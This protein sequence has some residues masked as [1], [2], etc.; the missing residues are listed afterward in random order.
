MSEPNRMRFHPIAVEICE[1]N[2]MAAL[3]DILE[4][5]ESGYDSSA[6]DYERLDHI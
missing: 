4:D 1:G 5:H 2:L 6:W 3:G